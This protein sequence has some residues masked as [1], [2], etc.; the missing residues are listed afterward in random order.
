[1]SS[2]NDGQ[3]WLRFIGWAAPMLLVAGGCIGSDTTKCG[4]DVCPEGWVCDPQHTLCVRPSQLTLCNELGEGEP[5]IVLGVEGYHCDLGV[6]VE[7][8]CGDGITDVGEECDDGDANSDT[9]PD[10]CR[11][12]NCVLPICGDGVIDSTEICDNGSANSDTTAD[13]CRTTCDAAGCGDGQLDTGES[14][15][16]GN[17][18]TLDGCEVCAP[19]MFRANTYLVGSQGSATV[20]MSTGGDFVVG[21]QCGDRGGVYA[22]FF[23]APS[24]AVGDEVRLDDSVGNPASLR[25]EISDSG[26]VAALWEEP[27]GLVLR[28]F[29]ATGAALSDE[30]PVCQAGDSCG[31]SAALAMAPDGQLTVVWRGS[32]NALWGRRFTAS[33]QP[34]GDAILVSAGGSG[35]TVAMSASGDLVV[36]WILSGM[37]FLQRVNAAGQLVGV[38][39]QVDGGDYAT[40]SPRVSMASDGSYVLAWQSYEPSSNE[41]QVLMRLYLADGMPASPVTRVDADDTD[42]RSSVRASMFP[43]G[44]FI[45]SWR[46]D[47]NSNFDA[48]LWVQRFDAGAQPLGAPTEV[49]YP[50]PIRNGD[51]SAGPDGSFVATFDANDLSTWD[52]HGRLYVP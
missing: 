6:C 39:E 41:E 36:A 18:V 33:G 1:M 14:C 8:V 27:T 10:A 16:D 3:T 42:M 52:I 19:A 25:L 12:D 21:W 51:V 44:G 13:A 26:D 38:A 20:A 5:C 34:E 31:G 15:D 49:T 2:R 24:V 9:A 28:L 23:S 4:Q 50:E 45:V 30:L 43:G 22:R 17:E 37:I 35:P 40:Y 48:P 11:A 47:H 29:T 7:G 46:G 32:D